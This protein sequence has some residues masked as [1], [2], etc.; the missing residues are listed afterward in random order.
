MY[1][2]RLFDCK[3]KINNKKRMIYRIYVN[4]NWFI[5]WHNKFNFK[6]DV[7]IGLKNDLVTTYK[8]LSQRQKSCHNVKKTC[9]HVKHTHYTNN[10]LQRLAT[11]RHELSRV[12]LL[13]KTCYFLK[14]LVVKRIMFCCQK[15]TLFR[16]GIPA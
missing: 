12:F 1:Y 8:N 7:Y 4:K 14:K 13:P 9:H 5:L 11:S 2:L 15:V 16:C 6:S 10:E 3:I